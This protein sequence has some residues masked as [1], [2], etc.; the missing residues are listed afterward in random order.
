MGDLEPREPVE[1]GAFDDDE[2]PSTISTSGDRATA[3]AT[4]RTDSGATFGSS[5]SAGRTTPGVRSV[6]ITSMWRW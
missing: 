3:P 4:S 6:S 5:S 2:A 1:V